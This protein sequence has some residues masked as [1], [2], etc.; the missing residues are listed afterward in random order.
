MKENLETKINF[1]SGV[2]ENIDLSKFKSILVITGT[3]HSLG[4][5]EEKVRP[6]LNKKAKKFIVWTNISSNLTDSEVYMVMNFASGNNIDCVISVGAD[7]VMDCGRLVSLLLSHGGF[8]HD[9]LPGGSIGPNG[10]T[11][12]VMHHI[13]IPT[14][15]SA[16]SEISSRALFRHSGKI[17]KISSP[18][19][20]PDEAF[21]DPLIMTNLPGD[22]WA[23]RGFD[24][25]A[26]AI[27]AYI[28]KMANDVSDAFA[29]STLESYIKHARNLVKRPDNI[30]NIKHA[31][32]ASMNAFLAGN[33]SNSAYISIVANALVSK[34]G[35]RRGV[36]QAIVCGEVCA[37][38]YRLNPVRFD[39]I[40]EMLG[41]QGGSGTAVK[42]EINRLVK[43]LGIKLPKTL[44]ETKD[45]QTILKG[46]K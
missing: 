13:T 16:G 23:I 32:A 38:L 45:I 36:A 31:C 2:L 46:A 29:V 26:T 9:Y 43:D 27:D 37:Y 17:E 20:V 8:L 22:L 21:I 33:Y 28:C 40:A 3:Q 4:V 35:V 34:L 5:F 42:K 12:Q 1:D 14:M 19:L 24:A 39:K 18:Y 10:V 7:A 25:F 15:P 6:V 41:G 44:I 11:A 30:E